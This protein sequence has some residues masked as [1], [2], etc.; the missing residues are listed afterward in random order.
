MRRMI[1]IRKLQNW[2][3]KGDIKS[4]E[5]EKCFLKLMITFHFSYLGNLAVS[6]LGKLVLWFSASELSFSRM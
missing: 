5:L 6:I 4:L 1:K 3:G 2:R